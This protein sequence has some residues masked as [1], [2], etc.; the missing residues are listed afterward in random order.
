MPM[1]SQHLP[2]PQG[3]PYPGPPPKQPRRRTYDPPAVA[4]GNASL[5][6]LGYFL[7]RRPLFGLL[8]LAGTA[9][10][11][12]LMY[13]R[14]DTAYQFALLGWGLLQIVHGYWLAHRQTDRTS[15]IPKRIVAVVITLSVV[16]TAIVLKRGAAAVEDEVTAARESG[17][18]V[19]VVR[20]QG[21]V[22]FGDRLVAGRAMDRGDRDA[23]ICGTLSAADGRLYTAT[24]QTDLT[25]LQEAYEALAEIAAD[26]RQQRTAGVVMDRFV[27]DLQGMSPCA[28]ID[29][30][31]WLRDRPLTHNLLDRANAVVP[32]IEPNALLA[33]ADSHASQ[34]EWQE[35][36]TI[37]QR[38]VSGYPK[39]KQSVRG[40]AGVTRASLAIE[41]KEVD[42]LMD[43]GEYCSKPAR[44]RGAKPY[45]RGLNGAV[46]L[47][48][49]VAYSL[50]LPSEWMSPV[51]QARIVVCTG[52]EGLGAAVKTCP[53]VPE[54]SPSGPVTNVTFRKVTIPVK[55]Y[56]L[57]TARLVQATTLSISGES[58]PYYLSNWYT[59]DRTRAVTPS[60]AQVQAVFRP[61]LV[62]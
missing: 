57:R 41:L 24:Q 28:V 13:Q 50:K 21:N 40:R 11:L 49:S 31:A 34:E 10:L 42:R 3:T 61:L 51:S 25:A 16:G 30:T 2:P 39:A 60:N 4:L 55:V 47:G 46:F 58:C 62:R 53:Y 29:V 38:L 59:G 12:V 22:W 44:Y 7:V 43:S 33:C 52:K 26:P 36:L 35:A 54:T 37:Y 48:E 5:L 27:K 18:C 56:E 23:E 1:S 8:G 45:G 14:K 19:G 17:D 6:G 9:T 20:A 15:S 32:R